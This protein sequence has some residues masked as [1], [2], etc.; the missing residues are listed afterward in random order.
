MYITNSK[1][2]LTNIKS[3]AL[4]PNLGLLKMWAIRSIPSDKNEGGEGVHLVERRS[5]AS[6]L[7]FGQIW[8]DWRRGCRGGERSLCLEEKNRERVKM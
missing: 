4:S 8:S 2:I 1:Q 7:R 5:E 6:P 3:L